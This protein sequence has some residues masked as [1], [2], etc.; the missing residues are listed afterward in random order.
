MSQESLNTLRDY[1]LVTLQPSD[2]HWL[3]NILL[4]HSRE[5][6]AMRAYTKEEIN[7]MMDE[8]ERQFEAGEYHTDDEVF[9]R[10]YNKYGLSKEAT[11]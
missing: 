8:A 7:A 6:E 5:K 9:E 10:L 3:G 2:M 11:V 4:E 1:L